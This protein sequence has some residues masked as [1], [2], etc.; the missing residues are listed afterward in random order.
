MGA[1]TGAA[2]VVGTAGDTEPAPVGCEGITGATAARVPSKAGGAGTALASIGTL[3]AAAATCADGVSAC[4]GVLLGTLVESTTAPCGGTI[5]ALE[6]PL[7]TELNPCAC[8]ATNG[9]ANA[10]ASARADRKWCN[11]TGDAVIAR[12]FYSSSGIF[13]VSS[14]TS[15]VFNA[16]TRV[17][18][19][20]VA[21][22]H[23][24]AC[25]PRPVL[26]PLPASGGGTTGIPGDSAQG[27]RQ[28]AASRP[29]LNS[30]AGSYGPVPRPWPSASSG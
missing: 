26:P 23:A 9:V 1:G 2:G 27:R 10:V 15:P 25:G 16:S 20:G 12:R 22:A 4:G 11:R 30:T 3:S 28:R 14:L 6:V 21:D 29:A 5:V 18:N 17:T 19:L 7:D 13:A 24:V 8:V